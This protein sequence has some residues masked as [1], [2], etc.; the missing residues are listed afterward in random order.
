V[1]EGNSEGFEGFEPTFTLYSSFSPHE[2]RLKS[3]SKC[4]RCSLKKAYGDDV[5][6]TA[7]ITSLTRE[8]TGWRLRFTCSDQ[9]DFWEVVEAIKARIP[10]YA[11]RFLPADKCWWIDGYEL[12]ELAGIFPNF[13]EMRNGGGGWTG[14]NERKSS[15]TKSPPSESD[16]IPAAVRRSFAVLYLLPEA[17]PDVIKA[18]YRACAT[19]HHP[20]HGGETEM[21]KQVNLAFELSYQWAMQHQAQS[22]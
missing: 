13:H 5:W 15:Y 6:H 12:D 3:G 7:R 17:P 9:D 11:R 1:S 16:R 21:M 19:V 4:S 8:G 14:S 2:G 10:R 22:A 20:D 18:A